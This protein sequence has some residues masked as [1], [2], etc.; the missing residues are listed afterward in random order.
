MCKSRCD[1]N[2]KRY[3]NFRGVG[4]ILLFDPLTPHLPKNWFVFD[5]FA[6]RNPARFG[7]FTGY[8]IN[9]A[10]HAKQGAVNCFSP[11]S[12][13]FSNTNGPLFPTKQTVSCE[14]VNVSPVVN[15]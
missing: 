13:V 9:S 14:H 4:S 7:L 1:E 10:L 12:K 3:R 5:Y 8:K 15:L 11:F 6:L 2:T